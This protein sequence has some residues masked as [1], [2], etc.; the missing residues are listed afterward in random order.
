MA[1]VMAIQVAS[2]A[3]H[4]CLQIEVE[5]GWGWGQE[6]GIIFQVSSMY[7][8]VFVSTK[9]DIYSCILHFCNLFVVFVYIN[10]CIS[11]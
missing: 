10:I 3:T 6:R 9:S 2:T 5:V 4:F 1:T 11:V 8:C 7:M